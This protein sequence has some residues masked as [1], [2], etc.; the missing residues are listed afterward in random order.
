AGAA[1]LAEPVRDTIKRVVDGRIVETP[2]RQ[3]CWAAQTPQVVR[4]DWLEDGLASASAA[5]RLA[6]DDAQLVEWL[7]R[8]VRVVASRRPN[9]KITRPEDLVAARAM[10]NAGSGEMGGSIA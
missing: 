2:P 3:E 5:G 10:L 7:G 4:R 9:P 1:I 6:T 8:E